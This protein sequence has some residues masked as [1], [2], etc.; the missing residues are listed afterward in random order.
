MS[1][2]CDVC[3]KDSRDDATVKENRVFVQAMD[4]P[5]TSVIVHLCADDRTKLVTEINKVLATM[6]LPE[7]Q[8]P[9]VTPKWEPPESPVTAEGQLLEENQ[10]NP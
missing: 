1:M 6:Q 5:N 9:F 8:E 2:A 4:E 7:M 10:D 3:G